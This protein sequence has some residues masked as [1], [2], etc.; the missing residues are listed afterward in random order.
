[1]ARKFIVQNSEELERMVEYY[2]VDLSIAIVEAILAN[3]KKKKKYI[4]VAEIH[5]I[6]E[7]DIADLSVEREDVLD[8]L[9]KNLKILEN[10]EE[11]ELC[12]KVAKL[13]NEIK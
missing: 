11:Y 1:M 13:I 2:D 7:D 8:T 4:H 6:E 10:N 5:I 9:E 3:Y 12:S